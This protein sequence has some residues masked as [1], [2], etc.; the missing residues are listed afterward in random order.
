MKKLLFS[1]IFCLLMS[2]QAYGQF[3]TNGSNNFTSL[4]AA[5]AVVM[6]GG[7]ITMTSNVDMGLSVAEL[8]VSK[9]YTIDLGGKTL[10]NTNY[11]TLEIQA[12]TVTIKNGSITNT[13]TEGDGIRIYSISVLDGLT[14]SAETLAVANYGTVF[15][16]S[17]TYIGGEDALYC[18]LSTAT[19][20]SGHFLCTNDSGN[21]C[22]VEYDSNAQI[23][24]AEGSTPNVVPWKNDASAIDVIITTASSV[25]ETLHDTV[26]PKGYYSILGIKLPQEPESGIYIIL[27]DNG[28][29]KKVIK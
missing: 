3:T 15:I 5:A 12:G 13:S 23:F 9:T 20:T 16:L 22:L 1:S 17:G 4:E 27:Y 19:I 21:G 14:V 2:T 18:D 25:E 7:T 26:L 8:N 24:L 11:S 6:D 29:A 28:K 10:L